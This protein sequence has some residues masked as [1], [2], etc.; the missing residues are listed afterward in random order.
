MYNIRKNRLYNAPLPKGVFAK[1][2]KDL[3]KLDKKELVEILLFLC[4]TDKSVREA[5]LEN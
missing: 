3:A 5:I 1:I 4:K 2:K